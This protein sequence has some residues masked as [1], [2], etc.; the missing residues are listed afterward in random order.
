M[1]RILVTAAGGSPSTNFVRSLRAAPEP[2][3]LIGVDANAYHLQRAETDER[4]LVP[5]ASASDFLDILER[6]AQDTDA[7][8]IHS[9]ADVEI[10]VLSEARG[11]FTAAG[12]RLFLPSHETVLVCQNKFISFQR[13]RAAGLRVPDTMMVRSE[14]D[15]TEAFNRFGS[16]VWIRA[17]SGAAG[18]G[19]FP[20][21]TLQQAIAW[22]EFHDGWGGF[23]AAECMGSDST[24]W[25]SLWK[26]GELIVAQSRKR[27][28]WELGNRAPSGVTGITGAGLTVDDAQVNEISLQAIRAVDA[29]P[30]GIFSV[31]LTYDRDGIPNPTEIN[32]GRFF[33]THNFFT[34]AGLNMPHFY[35]KAAFDEPLPALA[36]RINPLPGGLLWIRG[37]DFLPIL[38]HERDIERCIAEL[39]RRRR[40]AG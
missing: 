32:I 38:S 24:T 20:A 22:V 27:L 13:W 6:I 9:Q 19:A 25:M 4:Y 21:R 34:A 11:R 17:V 36:S 33:T 30:D 3:H 14:A 18:R 37:V 10:A 5:P 26:N 23:S 8:L 35:V 28:Y 31:D 15:L 40:G 2:Y 39:A 7:E 16:P 12:I 1:R 29:E